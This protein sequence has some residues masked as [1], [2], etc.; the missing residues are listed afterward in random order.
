[1][2]VK[3]SFLKRK[4]QPEVSVEGRL[5]WCAHTHSN[6]TL[7]HVLHTHTHTLSFKRNDRFQF[8]PSILNV[9]QG[10]SLLLLSTLLFKRAI[11]LKGVDTN[12]PLQSAVT[13][14]TTFFTSFIDN[15][16]CSGAQPKLSGWTPPP[17][18]P[19]S[20]CWCCSSATPGKRDLTLWGL[21][22]PLSCWQGGSDVCV[23]ARSSLN[24]CVCVSVRQRPVKRSLNEVPEQQ[25]WV[26]FDGHVICLFSPNS[27]LCWMRGGGS[28]HTYPLLTQRMSH[29]ILL[30]TAKS[31]LLAHSEP[32]RVWPFGSELLMEAT[33]QWKWC[34]CK[35]KTSALWSPQEWGWVREEAGRVWVRCTSNGERKTKSIRGRG[36]LWW[37]LQ[38]VGGFFSLL[39]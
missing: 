10:A 11:T 6:R 4:H 12:F 29:V 38:L 25:W 9:L 16:S 24:E 34:I 15:P 31:K 5:L 33:C 23:P 2:K 39:W 21:V 37:A 19:C 28:L 13:T 7:V 17:P 18:P 22:K 30:P 8:F 20:C 36:L 26:L 1:M 32:V 14:F 3:V 27:L 35:N